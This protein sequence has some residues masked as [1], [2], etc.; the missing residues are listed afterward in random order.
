MQDGDQLSPLCAEDA[1]EETGLCFNRED[2]DE[3]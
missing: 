3:L 2:F 1:K